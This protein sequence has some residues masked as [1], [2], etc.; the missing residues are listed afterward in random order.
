ML[1][2]KKK[3]IDIKSTKKKTAQGNSSLSKPRH[4]KKLKRG[5]G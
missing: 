2:N 5:Q 3:K 4:N 1:Y